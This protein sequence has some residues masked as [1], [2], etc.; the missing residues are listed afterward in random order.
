M[1]Q[2]KKVICPL[3]FVGV[4]AVSPLFAQNNEMAKALSEAFKDLASIQK[5]EKSLDPLSQ[6]DLSPGN[7]RVKSFTINV[8]PKIKKLEENFI[9]I[10]GKRTPVSQ[11]AYDFILKVASGVESVVAKESVQIGEYQFDQGMNVSVNE[12]LSDLA[13]RVVAQLDFESQASSEGKSLIDADYVAQLSAIVN[14]IKDQLERTV[15]RSKEMLQTKLKLAQ[16]ELKQY[17]IEMETYASPITF[18]V[19]APFMTECQKID[20]KNFKELKVYDFFVSSDSGESVKKY[21][22][23]GSVYCHVFK[24]VPD[25]KKRAT[26]K[27]GDVVGAWIYTDE[28]F[29]P[30]G[31]YIVLANRSGATLGNLGDNSKDD[32]TVLAQYLDPDKNMSNY[33][34]FL[35]IDLPNLGQGQVLSSKSR[36]HFSFKS[37][38]EGTTD[39]ADGMNRDSNMAKVLNLPRYDGFVMGKI[40][41]V[42]KSMICQNVYETHYRSDYGQFVEVS[43]CQGHYWP[44]VIHTDTYMA[45]LTQQGLNK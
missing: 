31:K 14:G 5:H 13:K 33:L 29:R 19:T 2:F 25:G 43:W 28:K 24:M 12:Y 39:M 22:K 4:M 32:Y 37:K 6:L 34:S 20:Q 10:S 44:T 41:N 27:K 40:K 42:M 17:F 7:G 9:N 8:F 38:V 36:E 35:P 11:G 18:N 30:Y 26:I 15:G 1:F 3:L 21:E 23:Y 16:E 45:I